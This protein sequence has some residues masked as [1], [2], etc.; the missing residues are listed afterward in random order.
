MPARKLFEDDD[1]F[2]AG[3]RW[4][5]TRLRCPT[6]DDFPEGLKYSFQYLSP[7]DEELLRYDNANDAHGGGRHHR[8]YRGEVEGIEFEGLRSHLEKFLDEVETIHE[9]EFA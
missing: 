1:E 8:H 5:R 2:P 6:S 9:Q 7:A 4:K 3:D